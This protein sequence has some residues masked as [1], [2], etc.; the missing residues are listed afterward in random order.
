MASIWRMAAGG[1]KRGG[2][3]SNERRGGRKWRQSYRNKSSER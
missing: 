2:G 3:V 1:V